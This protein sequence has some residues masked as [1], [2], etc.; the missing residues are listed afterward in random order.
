MTESVVRWIGF[1]VGLAVLGAVVLSVV[2][3]LVVPRRVASRLTLGGTWVRSVFLFFSSRVDDYET[4][5]RILSYQGPL[6]LLVMLNTWL[7]ALWLA[8]AL[9]LWPLIDESFFAA[10]RESGSSI[11]TLG[12]AAHLDPDATVVYFLAAATGLIVV[13]LLIAYLPTLYGSFNRRERL[14]TVLQSRAGIPA[15]GPEILYRHHT[16]GIVGSL[17]DLYSDWEHWAADVAES[18][19]NYPI[20]ITFRSPHPLRSW[21]VSLLAV[22]DSAALYLALCPNSAPAEARLCLRMGFVALREVADA[23]GIPY[24]PDPTPD[25]PIELTYEEYAAGI[26][27]MGDFPIERTPEDAWVHFRGWRVNYERIA[28]GLADFVVATPAPWS[29]DRTQMPGLAIVP[30]RPA[31]RIA[32]DPERHEQPKVSGPDWRLRG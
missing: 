11:L 6:A 8:F 17:K 30:Q 9:L 28:Y 21:V 12:F 3:T 13:A 5:D 16:V 27:R 14:V 4:K 20:L 7:M 10:L 26:A 22:L 24:D 18:H 32:G 15:W 31:N 29:G 25:D 19:T 23:V 1:A 2:K